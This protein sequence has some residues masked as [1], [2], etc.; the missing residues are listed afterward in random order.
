MNVVLIGIATLESP[1]PHHPHLPFPLLLNTTP[2]E[3]QLG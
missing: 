3:E 1:P 2:K